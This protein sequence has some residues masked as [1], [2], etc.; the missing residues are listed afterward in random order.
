MSRM[1]PPVLRSIPRR[2]NDAIDRLTLVVRPIL[3]R[4]WMSDALMASRPGRVFVLVATGVI[5]V[6]TV[7]WTVQLVSYVLA[8]GGVGTDYFQYQAQVDRW[9]A[10]GEF[11][12]PRQLAGQTII[13]PGDP[14]YPPWA[15]YLFAPFHYL[16]AILWWL[17]PL[18]LIGVIIAWHRPAPWTWPF[19]L[20]IFCWP[21]TPASILYGNTT[22][23]TSA[24]VA[25]A[26]VWRWP[27]PLVLFK[28]SFAPFA[29]VGI[30]SR[31]WWITLLAVGL[32]AIPLGALW[33]D[34]LTVVRNVRPVLTYS[35]LDLPLVLAPLVAAYGARR[36]RSAEAAPKPAA[37]R[38]AVPAEVVR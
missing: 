5:A 26:T 10:T 33:L 20:L 34:Y 9:L 16:P 6:L 1:T 37:H 24:I 22:M 15:L 23:W 14:I 21:K 35:I 18:T 19:L 27:G 2:A 11:Y 31:G 30:R 32:A 28:P 17:I 25:A 3:R 29:L 12:L 38:Q 8:I 4:P 13:E 36:G 7:I